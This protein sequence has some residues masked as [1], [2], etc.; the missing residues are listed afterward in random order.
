MQPA[1][2]SNAYSTRWRKYMADN[3]WHLDRRVPVSI[4]I[5]LVLQFVGGLWFAFELRSDIDTNARDI[6][7]IERSVEVMSVSSQ[8]QAVQL[9]RIEEQVSGLRA[10]IQRLLARL[11]AQP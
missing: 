8:Q 9:G 7:R 5:V 2:L 10:D 6:A 4:I 11:E 1:L 3:G